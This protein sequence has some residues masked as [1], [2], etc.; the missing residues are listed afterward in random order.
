M[1]IETLNLLPCLN[2]LMSCQLYNVATQTMV[3]DKDNTFAFLVLSPCI[4]IKVFFKRFDE[5]YNQGGISAQPGETLAL[6]QNF[7]EG[8]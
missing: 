7:F 1:C 3:F 5:I 6:A 2:F 8:F 4:T